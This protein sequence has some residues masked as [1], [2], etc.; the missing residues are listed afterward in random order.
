MLSAI[1]DV[2]TDP[3]KELS[4]SE[5]VVLFFPPSIIHIQIVFCLFCYTKI[6]TG[7]FI[8]KIIRQVVTVEYISALEIDIL[9]G[10]VFSRHLKTELEVL[11]YIEWLQ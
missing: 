4:V 5:P 6:I 1:T 7:L 10:N 3:R 11:K 9:P 8:I 2:L